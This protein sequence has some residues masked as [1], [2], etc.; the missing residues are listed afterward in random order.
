MSDVRLSTPTEMLRLIDTAEVLGLDLETTGL[1]PRTD[2]VR[3]LSLADAHRSAV[4]DC[5]ESDP[6]PVVRALRGKTLIC[7]FFTM[8]DHRIGGSGRAAN[9]TPD[10]NHNRHSGRPIMAAIRST[11]PRL[12]QQ[13]I[14]RFWS[15]VDRRGPN[16]CWPW[17]RSHTTKGYGC[18]SLGCRLRLAHRVAFF[19]GTGRWPTACV[20]HHCD[21]PPCC[22]P[23]HLFEGTHSDNNRDAARKGRNFFTRHPELV[24]R[25]ERLRWAKLTAP[26]V[27]EIRRRHAEGAT[28]AALG[29]EFGVTYQSVRAVV[30]RES[31][32]HIQ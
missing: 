28:L 6:R 12:T 31:W 11:A 22:N 26:L 7:W 5:F 19:I 10:P 8:M 1:N 24:L 23:A 18:F 15:K 21:N 20:C 30:R 32:R 27:I 2:R 4:M 25:G 14:E 9:T 17:L 29:R 13:D 3:L 16:E